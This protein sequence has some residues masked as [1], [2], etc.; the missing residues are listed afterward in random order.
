MDWRDALYIALVTFLTL[1]LIHQFAPA[2]L[3]AYT[4]TT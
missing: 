3:K 1:V 4:G 2:S